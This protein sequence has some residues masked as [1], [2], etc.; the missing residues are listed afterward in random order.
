MP[1]KRPKKISERYLE[2]SAAFYLDRYDSSAAN[3][4]RVLMRKV[5]N[6]LREHGGDR[7][8]ARRWVD[9]LVTRFQEGGLVD[10]DRYAKTKAGSLHRR[11][12]S[13][14]QIQM[15]LR[16]KGLDDDSINHAMGKLREEA[17]S[18][19]LEA[20]IGWAKRRRIGPYRADLSTRG[21]KRQKDM[22]VL[23]RRGFPYDIVK[24]VIDAESEDELYE[25]IQESYE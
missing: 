16:S 18:P 21:D 15:K 13:T 4:K 3:L 10:D 5:Y 2:R 6:S 20:A 8:E 11:G 12:N 25:L 19:D 22:A 1:R 17:P 23:A 24:Q 14:R 9:E 7:E